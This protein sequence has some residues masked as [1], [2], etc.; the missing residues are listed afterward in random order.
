MSDSHAIPEDTEIQ[1][2][3]V[4]KTLS[5]GMVVEVKLVKRLRWFEA[6]MFVNGL[7]KPG[8]PLPRPLDEPTATASHWMGVRP[9][10]GL[11]PEE[12]EAIVGEVNVQNYLHKCQLVDK[13]GHNEI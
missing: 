11:S 4:E 9:K 2:T 1:E 10:I 6:M 7:Y 8:P 3:I 13:W 5:N 12:V